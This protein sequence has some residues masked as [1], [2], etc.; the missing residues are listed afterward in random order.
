MEKNLN[1]L[2][3]D[4]KK[5]L[6]SR[7]RFLKKAAIYTGST[8][9][10]LSLIPLLEQNSILAAIVSDGD[11]LKSEMVKYQGKSGQIMAYLA[12]PASG[13][14]YPAVI[15]IH[16]NR[17]LQPHIKDVT[18][19]MAA[20]GFLALAPDGLSPLGGTPEDEDEARNRIGQLDMEVTTQ[21]FSAAVKY[22]K[23]HPD[24]NGKV[25]CTGFCWGGGMTNRVAVN[26]P[27]LDAAVPYYGSTPPPEDVPKIKSPVMA[28]YAGDD[29][30][31]N[32]GIPAFEKALKEAGIEYRIFMYEGAMHAFNNDSNPARYNKE[33]ADLAWERTIEFFRGKLDQGKD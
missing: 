27:D 8:S 15:I 2:V 6:I 16:E 9:L 5:G 21:D 23:S 20:E 10:A 25:G 31:I 19:R 26:A 29:P 14:K 18:R 1:N 33:A 24:S 11:E 7:R 4:F 30:R 12:K 13:K 28:H 3:S 32:A 17:G 22:L